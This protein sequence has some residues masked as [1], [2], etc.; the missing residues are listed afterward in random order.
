M[1]Q[2]QQ[3]F[4]Q[5]LDSPCHKLFTEM[6]PEFQEGYLSYVFQTEKRIFKKGASKISIK[7]FTA[8]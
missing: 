8:L 5:G 2:N 3:D 1:N 6:I 4:E 7:V